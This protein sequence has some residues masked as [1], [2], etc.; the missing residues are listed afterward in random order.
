[1]A[2][3]HRHLE[4]QAIVT[5]GI[6]DLWRAAEEREHASLLSI[7]YERWRNGTPGRF[8]VDLLGTSTTPNQ[9]AGATDIRTNAAT[10]LLDGAAAQRTAL[11]CGDTSLSYGE[12][13]GRVA[14]WRGKPTNNQ[15]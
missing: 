15:T 5:N 13:R 3:H 11:V 9:V 1:M 2:L 6:A 4:E 7:E 14:R 8:S 10:V 12:L